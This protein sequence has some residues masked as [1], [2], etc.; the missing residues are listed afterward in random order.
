MVFSALGTNL[1]GRRKGGWDKPLELLEES[2]SLN[3]PGNK[4]CGDRTDAQ[5]MKP[6]GRTCPLYTDPQCQATSLTLGGLVG[7]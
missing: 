6:S 5:T 2:Y 7:N 3:S 1:F 4:E